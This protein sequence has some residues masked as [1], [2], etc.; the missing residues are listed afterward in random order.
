MVFFRF[1]DD[2]GAARLFH[3]DTI[4]I[5]FEM[6]LLDGGKVTTLPNFL[7]AWRDVC[8]ERRMYFPSKGSYAWRYIGKYLRGARMWYPHVQRRSTPLTLALLRFVFEDVGIT[9]AACLETCSIAVLS[10]CAR[11]LAAH[12]AM[13]RTCAHMSG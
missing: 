10:F 4:I 9:S 2:I 3:P 6:W 8:D 7:S 12:A 1:C 11:L 13:M 5:F